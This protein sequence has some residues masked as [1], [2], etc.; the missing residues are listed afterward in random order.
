MP[1]TIFARETAAAATAAAATAAA[2][3]AAAATAAAATAAAATAAAATAAAGVQERPI[4]TLCVL[5][6][7][8][9]VPGGT[10]SVPFLPETRSKLPGRAL[11]VP[12]RV[13]GR[14]R[15]RPACSGTRPVRPG[16]RPV[17]PRT[18]PV[19]PGTYSFQRDSFDFAPPSSLPSLE[20]FATL[21]FRLP[22]FSSRSLPILAFPF[23]SA[24]LKKSRAGKIN[25]NAA[26]SAAT[27][28]IALKRSCLQERKSLTRQE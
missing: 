26:R 24:L 3:T 7:T 11:G 25:P 8:R 10:G 15:T 14:P 6:H 2:A 20:P 18:L 22:L 17:L 4:S 27:L 23:P 12:G 28:Y 9:R 19:L 13:P 5:G 1:A 16:A 21:R